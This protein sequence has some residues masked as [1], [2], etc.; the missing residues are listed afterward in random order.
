MNKTKHFLNLTRI[1]EGAARMKSLLTQ[2]VTTGKIV[3]S[4]TM[5]SAEF[6]KLEKVSCDMSKKIDSVIKD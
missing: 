6:G 5:S 3:V 2:S 4:R 1:I